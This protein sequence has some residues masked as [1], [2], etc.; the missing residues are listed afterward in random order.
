[1]LKQRLITALCGIPILIVVIWFDKPLPWFTIFMALWGAVAV[2]EFYNI[3]ASSKV[4]PLTYFGIIWTVFFILSP[5][6]EYGF[7]PLLIFASSVFLSP[8]LLMLRRRKELFFA[9]WLWTMAGILYVGWLL[10]YLVALRLEVGREWV[11]LAF[12]TVFGSDT[13]AFFIGKALGRHRLA[14][15]ISPAKTWEGAIGGLFGAVIVS[16]IVVTVFSMPLSFGQAIFLGFL[17]S[18]IAQL[19]DLLESLFKRKT[20]TKESGRL[21]PGHG[22]LLDRMDSVVFAGVVVYLYYVIVVL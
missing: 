1:M 7:L 9:S 15:R 3:I 16:L 19:G 22:G 4:P 12:F 18:I 5:H 2:Y 13:T 6:F 11:L 10:S 17:V 8:L 21:L 14:P 20:G